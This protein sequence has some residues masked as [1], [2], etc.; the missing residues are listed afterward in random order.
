M[1]NA[2]EKIR[3]DTESTLMLG[4]TAADPVNIG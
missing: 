4:Y 2:K 1:P 3:V